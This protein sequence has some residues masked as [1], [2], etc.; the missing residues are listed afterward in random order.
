ME[1]IGGDIN[2]CNGDVLTV[3]N[4]GHDIARFVAHVLGKE[5]AAADDLS[6]LSL[7]NS[8]LDVLVNQF[9][10]LSLLD[11]HELVAVLDECSTENLVLAI[12]NA[13]CGP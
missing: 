13:E 5:S 9:P 3:L 6:D 8:F 2:D 12:V 11:E 4:E 10:F 1:V 7:S